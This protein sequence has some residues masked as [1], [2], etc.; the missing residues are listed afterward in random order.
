MARRLKGK[1]GAAVADETPKDVEPQAELEGMKASVQGDQSS[2]P[3]IPKMG[4]KVQRVVTHVF[5]VDVADA[6][7]KLEGEL[8]LDDALTPQA[9]RRA[10]NRVERYAQLAHQLY[11]ASKVEQEVF[12]V[13]SEKVLGA[14]RTQAVE[15][16]SLEKE[17]K[18]FTKQITEADI[19]LRM[20]DMF[21]DEWDEIQARR[22]RFSG[23]VEH[24]KRLA[25]LWQSRCRSLASLNHNG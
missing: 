7:E 22:L 25:E 4:P 15:K 12:E 5:D 8:A 10:L 24:L 13:Q 17:A 20:A 1:V 6:Y 3:E 18:L 11:I 23:A 9:V 16:L 21:P 19:K 14:M 2:L